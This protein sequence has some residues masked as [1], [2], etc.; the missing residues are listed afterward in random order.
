QKGFIPTYFSN[1]ERAEEHG[2]MYLE[3]AREAGHDFVLGQ[4]QATVRWL[5]LGETHQDALDA[6]EKYDAEIQRNFY[7]QLDTVA[8]RAIQEAID[9]GVAVPGSVGRVPPAP[10]DAP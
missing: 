4:N 10:L 6:V 1:I 7:N 3:A 9:R 2:P 8:Q 5:Q